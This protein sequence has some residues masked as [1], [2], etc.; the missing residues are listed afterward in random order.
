LI[1][2]A[3]LVG[4]AGHTTPLQ[5]ATATHNTL[6]LAQDI[7]AQICFGVADAY[8]SPTGPAAQ[9]CTT[10]TAATVQLTDVR[11]QQLN[12]KL[13]DAFNLQHAFEVAAAAGSA[14]DP[15]TLNAAVQEALTIALQLV[16]TPIVQQL[17]ANIQAGVK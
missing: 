2:L 16:Q 4:C 10:P 13:R 3:A 11:H 14:A 8:H 7:E 9:H 5:V 15:K 1:A 17:V 12:A 6:A